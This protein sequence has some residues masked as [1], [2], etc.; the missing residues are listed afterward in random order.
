MHEA[1]SRREEGGVRFNAMNHIVAV[2]GGALG[3]SGSATGGWEGRDWYFPKK[4][5]SHLSL[6][7]S[8]KL[9]S[10]TATILTRR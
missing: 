4:L 6:T 10:V 7:L 5:A 2:V 8:M 1:R 9:S 3:G